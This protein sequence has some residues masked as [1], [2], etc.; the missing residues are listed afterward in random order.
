MPRHAYKRLSVKPDKVYQSLE[1]A[2]FINY[3]MLEG[4]K[5]VAERLVYDVFEKLKSQGQEPIKVFH[6]AID[7]VSP[8]HE[9]KP[10][11]LGG[12]SYL[13]PIEVRRSRKLYLALNWIIT[14]ARARSNK[15]FHSFAGKLLAEI[16]DAAKNL[17]AAVTK[18]AQTEKLAETNKAFSHLKW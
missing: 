9:V 12:A 4:K 14:A 13:V 10:R 8:L 7:N 6:Q 16:T 17:G 11:R 18:K 15:E 3:V 2:K 1:V 5:S